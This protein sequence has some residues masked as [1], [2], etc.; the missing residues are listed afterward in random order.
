[1]PL[2]FVEQIKRNGNKRIS[3]SSETITKTSTK[4]IKKSEEKRKSS[5]QQPCDNRKWYNDAGGFIEC[6]R[7]G[8][9]FLKHKKTRIFYNFFFI[10]QQVTDMGIKTPVSIL[11]EILSR[12]GITPS[13]E[14]V[15]I[16]GAHHEPTFRYRVWYN[17][18]DGKDFSHHT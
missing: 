10:K 1:M 11:Q 16:E 17:D 13:Y 15:R 3:H 14:L 4:T 5:Q 8:G 2:D 7:F 6:Y 9:K 12:Q 18:K